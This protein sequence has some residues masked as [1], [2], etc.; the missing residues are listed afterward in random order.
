MK[1]IMIALCLLGGSAV[2]AEPA[3]FTLLGDPDNPAV[4]TV[5][6]DPTPVA[7]S[8]GE[9]TLKVRVNRS[10]Q[11]ISRDGVVYRS[12]QSRVLFDCVNRSAKYISIDFY[13]QPTWKGEPH[14]SSVYTR[15][16]PRWMQFRDIEPNPT[17]RI[18]R[19]VCES[20]SVTNN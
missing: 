12:Y 1:K 20:A 3:W 10:A 16:E 2:E 9:R 7:V 15:E 8:G 18:V 5:E 4:N 19:A 11:R 14:Q 13:L 17:R 6:V